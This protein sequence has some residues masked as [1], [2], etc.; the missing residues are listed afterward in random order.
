MDLEVGVAA[1][2]SI[3]ILK[4]KV[5]S[6]LQ[7]FRSSRSCCSLSLFSLESCGKRG[8]KVEFL[9]WER[10]ADKGLQRPR[11]TKP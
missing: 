3:P 7:G 1:S 8:K 5:K 4:P 2:P 11:G 9:F 10:D 6:R